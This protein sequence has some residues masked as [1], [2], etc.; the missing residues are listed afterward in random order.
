MFFIQLKQCLED[1][2]VVETK[3]LFRHVL[4]AD[5]NHYRSADHQLLLVRTEH[6]WGVSDFR[7][8]Y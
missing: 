1:Y 2:S 4:F 5:S 8:V 7:D 3:L 6:L